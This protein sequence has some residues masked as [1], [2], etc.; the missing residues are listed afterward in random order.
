M[1]IRRRKRK[2]PQLAKRDALLSREMKRLEL[3]GK[4]ARARALLQTEPFDPS[5]A[6]VV[7][8]DCHWKYRNFSDAKNGAASSAMQTME[9]RDMAK[10]PVYDMGKRNSLFF[11]WMTIPKILDGFKL[12][13]AWGLL[14]PEALTDLDFDSKQYKSGFPWVKTVPTTG[15]ISTG[16]G[17]WVQGCSELCFLF[18]KGKVKKKPGNA[19]KGLIHGDD[20]HPVFYC[21]KG[22][23]HS[24]KPEELQT[25]LSRI[26]GGHMVELFARRPLSGW[27]TWGYDT[28]FELNANG[29]VPLWKDHP[30]LWAHR[31]VLEMKKGKRKGLRIKRRK[32]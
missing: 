7:V 10:I 21:P 31:K 2:D 11:V 19:V 30:A 29:V 17:F 26:V 14:E 8:I 6:D 28:G 1:K 15:N 32:R 12:M 22:G 27:Q 18:V 9:L 5:P 3:I 13:V 25:W 16:I 4:E 23:K 20:G 24:D